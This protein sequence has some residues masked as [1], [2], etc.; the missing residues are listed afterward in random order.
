MRYIKERKCL[1]M[2]K[3]YVKPDSELFAI[4]IS[5]NLAGSDSIGGDSISSSIQIKFTHSVSPCREY[6]TGD[7]TAKVNVEYG[8][9]A[10]K[11]YDELYGYVENNMNYA[12]YFRCFSK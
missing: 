12:M 11:Y 10:L 3:K 1:E 2:K 4:N 6:Y 7:T 8:S 5:E 9:D